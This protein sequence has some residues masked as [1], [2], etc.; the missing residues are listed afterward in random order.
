VWQA[1]Q[2][3]PAA[4]PEVRG[5]A[6]PKR[7]WLKGAKALSTIV[8]FSAEHNDYIV[9][10]EDLATIQ[11]RLAEAESGNGMC[12][13][14]QLPKERQKHFPSSPILVNAS[15]VAYVRPPAPAESTA[16]KNRGL[17]S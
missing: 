11:D 10:A 12:E 9:V 6:L 5:V 15:R 16:R 1:N 7:H 8:A 13:L 3:Q 17:A 2:A 4:L 14:T